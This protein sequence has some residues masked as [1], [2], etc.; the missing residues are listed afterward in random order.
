MTYSKTGRNL[1]YGLLMFLI[2]ALPLS[3]M[4]IMTAD[5]HG[6]D[7]YKAKCSQCH[8]LDGKGDT[9][10]GKMVKTPDLTDKANWKVEPTLEAVEKVIREGS[11]KMPK[12]AGKMSDEDISAAAA[13]TLKLTG[14]GNM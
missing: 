12:Y 2:A 4:L 10:M 3:A 7:V 8:G 6:E 1:A 13:H 9:K 5:D 14:M 11:G